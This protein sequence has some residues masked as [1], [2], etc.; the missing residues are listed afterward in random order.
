MCL[1]ILK[2]SPDVR[3]VIRFRTGVFISTLL[4]QNPPT[5]F[6]KRLWTKVF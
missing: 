2:L 4:I 6:E 5:F 1:E 3:Q